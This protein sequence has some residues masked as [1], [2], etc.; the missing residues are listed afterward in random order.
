MTDTTSVSLITDIVKIFKNLIKSKTLCRP[1][2]ISFATFTSYN[3]VH[4]RLVLLTNDIVNTYDIT[5]PINYQRVCD[6]IKYGATESSSLQN[7]ESSILNVNIHF[8]FLMDEGLHY[9]WQEYVYMCNKTFIHLLITNNI[10]TP[11]FCGKFD[12]HFKLSNESYCE[13]GTFVKEE[14]TKSLEYMIDI[15]RDTSIGFLP[16]EYIARRYKSINGM[17][18]IHYSDQ[19]EDY[20]KLDLENYPDWNEEIVKRTQEM[21]DLN[22]DEPHA[23]KKIVYTIKVIGSLN[24]SQNSAF[25]RL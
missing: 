15:G 13:N 4:K 24:I 21:A 7:M 16:G 1:D 23:K 22:L 3:K 20:H 11:C 10:K 2:L 17:H 8:G 6:Y 5:D 12:E 25:K 9:S 18:E 19:Y 14:Y